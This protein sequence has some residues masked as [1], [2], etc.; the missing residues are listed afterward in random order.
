MIFLKT[1]IFYQP[2]NKAH[3]Q[4]SNTWSCST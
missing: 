1:T 2:I 3:H 4:N